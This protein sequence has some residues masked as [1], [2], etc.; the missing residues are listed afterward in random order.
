M[1]RDTVTGM[2]NDFSKRPV[3]LRMPYIF[4]LGHLP[5]FSDIQIS[6]HLNEPLT[7]PKEFVTMFERGIDPDVKT[8]EIHHS[9]SDVRDEWPELAQINE[10]SEKVRARVMILYE[11]FPGGFHDRLARIMWMCFEHDCMHLETLLYLLVQDGNVK[12]PVGVSE[13]RGCVKERLS[14][15]E[16]A[17]YEGGDVVVG[18]NDDE[19]SDFD[20]GAEKTGFTWDNERPVHVLKNTPF[21]IQKRCVS[22]GEYADFLKGVSAELHESLTP[23]SWV[24]HENEWGVKSVF[25]VR[26][27]K[28]SCNQN[29]YVSQSQASAYA[30]VHGGRLPTEAEIVVLRRD[31]TVL[32]KLRNVGFASWGCVDMT[33]VGVEA[34]DGFECTSSVWEG[35]EGYKAGELYP[36]YS[37]DFVGGRWNVMIGGSWA[38]HPRMMRASFRNW[39]QRDYGVAFSCFRVVKN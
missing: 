32:D 19:A 27:I 29:V 20:E 36:G 11:K 22:V 5:A 4:Y 13:V 17:E 25:G 33:G 12:P 10:Y 7:E 24:K 14:P 23:E 8:L 1:F 21:K 38:T 35:Y 15:S 39:Y 26:G 34:G 18:V 37:S 16:W 9:H 31:V 6:R 30:E 3:N 2:I 28:E